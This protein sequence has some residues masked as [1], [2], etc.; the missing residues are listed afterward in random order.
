MRR[1]TEQVDRSYL[2]QA[3]P[4]PL[5]P[6]V[7]VNLLNDY[8]LERSL[9]T[10]LNPVLIGC[11]I[12]LIGL[13][14]LRAP[15]VVRAV[16]VAV[17]LAQTAL[18]ARRLWRRVRDDLALLRD[19]LAVRAHILRLRPFR[20]IT[21]AIEGALLDC[22]IPVGPRRTYM[23]SIWLADGDEAL[24]LANQGR[25]LVLCLPLTPG[26]WRVIEEVQSDIRYDRMGPMQTIPPDS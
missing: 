20:G 12:V 5:P 21:G 2:D 18:A 1:V 15:P 25:L 22:A 9:R 16:P 13:Y 23:G 11:V 3:P 4:R 19:G 14:A 7:I 8:A 6:G 17:I 10:F 26:T 24:R